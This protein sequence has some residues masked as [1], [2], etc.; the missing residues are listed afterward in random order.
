MMHVRKVGLSF[1]VGG[2]SVPAA[3]ELPIDAL[4]AGGGA[5]LEAVVWAGAARQAEGR[6][7]GFCL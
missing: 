7:N 5:Q 1:Q 6:W 2:I 4:H 3:A